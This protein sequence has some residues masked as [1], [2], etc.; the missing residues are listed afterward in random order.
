MS[1]NNQHVVPTDGDREKKVRWE[2]TPTT[3]AQDNHEIT[4]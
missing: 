1:G 4:S 2:R 3:T